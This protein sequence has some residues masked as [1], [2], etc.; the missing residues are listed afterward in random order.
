MRSDLAPAP[1]YVL[2]DTG[3]LCDKQGR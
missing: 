2:L 1:H 3:I